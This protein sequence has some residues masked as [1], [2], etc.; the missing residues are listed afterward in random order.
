MLRLLPFLLIM[1]G[2]FWMERESIDF[3]KR[4]DRPYVGDGNSGKAVVDL[5]ENPKYGALA[6]STDTS[7]WGSSKGYHNKEDAVSDAVRRCAE[8]GAT[9]CVVKTSAHSNCL[10]LAL[11]P[12]IKTKQNGAW[13]TGSAENEKDAVKRASENCGKHAHDCKIVDSFCN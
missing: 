2:I 12:R 5:V 3:L 6:V 13:G 4:D 7:A 11:S 8:S 10:A 1:A 9:D